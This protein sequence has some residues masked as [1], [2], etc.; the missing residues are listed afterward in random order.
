MSDRRKRQPAKTQEASDQRLHAHDGLNQTPAT[1]SERRL[2]TSLARPCNACK[3]PAPA[4]EDTTP[5]PRASRPSAASPGIDWA[6]ASQSWGASHITTPEGNRRHCCRPVTEPETKS[7]AMRLTAANIASETCLRPPPVL[8]S[9]GREWRAALGL[10]TGPPHVLPSCGREREAPLPSL[11]RGQR[12]VATE[13]SP[14]WFTAAPP[15]SLPLAPLLYMDGKG[16]L[17]ASDPSHLSS[18]V[19]RG[20]RPAWRWRYG[21]AAYPPG[22]LPGGSL[23]LA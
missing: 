9:F 5:P 11:W 2:R 20:G 15:S 17:E 1:P 10:L 14:D 6:F 22:S 21:A 3:E 19:T 18:A 16:N 23:P 13:A 4:P 12:G 7:A 8:P